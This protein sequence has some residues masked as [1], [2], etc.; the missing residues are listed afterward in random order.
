[1]L[2]L[3]YHNDG[4]LLTTLEILRQTWELPG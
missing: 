2:S 3:G 1:M 4:A